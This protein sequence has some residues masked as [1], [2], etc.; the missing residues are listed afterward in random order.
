MDLALQA[1]YKG[2]GKQSW[3]DKGY[4]GA[5]REEEGKG[6]KNPWQKGSDKKRDKRKVPRE[7]PEHVGRVIRQ[8]TLQRGVALTFSRTLASNMCLAFSR[9]HTL[10]HTWAQCVCVSF[11]DLLSDLLSGCI[12]LTT[13]HV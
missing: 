4:R 1:V 8:G 11:A 3:N 12:E 13:K 7:K 5:K 2:T 6:E 10:T 9:S